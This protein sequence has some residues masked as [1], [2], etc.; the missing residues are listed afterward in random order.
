MA[1]QNFTTLIS[2]T[3]DIMICGYN[4]Y[5]EDQQLCIEMLTPINLNFE[6]KDI[7]SGNDHLILTSGIFVSKIKIRIYMLFT[8][9]L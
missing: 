1:G 3:N 7:C 2:D 5:D 4:I 6:F 9:N 8:N